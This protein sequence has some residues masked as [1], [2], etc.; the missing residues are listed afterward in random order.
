MGWERYG[1]ELIG[2]GMLLDIIL[3]L[4]I[5][6]IIFRLT[7]RFYSAEKTKL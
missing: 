3:T 6:I 1:L 2:I 5:Q 4:L 7:E